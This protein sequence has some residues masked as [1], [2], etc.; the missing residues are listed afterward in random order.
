[1][2]CVE[3]VA[4]FAGF[5]GATVPPGEYG[6]RVSLGEGSAE[7]R[8]SVVPDPRVTATPEDIRAWSATL[9]ETASLLDEILSRL[10][11]AR[12]AR[13]QIENLLAEHPD[14]TGLRQAGEAAI[15]AITAWDRAINQHLHQT[16]EDED[17]WETMLAGQ[18][19]YLLDV[20]D[21][22]GA[23]VTGGQ[24]ERLADL[25]AEWAQRRQELQAIRTD[26]LEP[27][28]ARARDAGIRHVSLPEA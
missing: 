21:A 5:G 11:E 9:G 10:D 22:T 28:N 27:I 1:V 12:K 26:H 14:D 15:A 13:T 25:Q 24:R 2:H 3:D 18:V 23:P 7:T 8:F 16:Y 17:A 19:R 20:I 4:L 6:A